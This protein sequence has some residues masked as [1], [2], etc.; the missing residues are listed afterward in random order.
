MGTIASQIT[1]LTIVYSTVYSGA[2]QRKHQR[3]TSL[4]FLR[5]INRWLVNS[6]AQRASNA[7]NVSTSWRNH[8]NIRLQQILSMC[9]RSSSELQWLDYTRGHL[10]SSHR[11]DC[12]WYCCNGTVIIILIITV[13]SLIHGSQIP[14]IK[15]FAS[16]LAVVFAYSVETR[17]KVE[18]EDVVG[19]APTG[20]APTISKWSTS[21][22]PSK[23]CLILEISR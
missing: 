17:C 11:I 1:N 18:N 9:A 5:G 23:V 3:S 13:K 8:V 21:L 16:R 6:T 4:A 14:K 20:D 19:A 10:H 22:L 7:E 12:H 2:D 15:R